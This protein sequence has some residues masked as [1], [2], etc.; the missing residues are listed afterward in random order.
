MKES[1]I[2]DFI[3][4]IHS[5]DFYNKIQIITE[6]NGEQTETFYFYEGGIGHAI[7]VTKSDGSVETIQDTE[8]ISVKFVIENIQK[9]SPESKMII[10]GNSGDNILTVKI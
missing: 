2:K 9:I 5:S 8:E 1:I 4:L 6:N 7:L 3:N 10:A